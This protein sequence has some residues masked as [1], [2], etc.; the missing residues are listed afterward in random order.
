MSK[1]A[2][3]LA[4]FALLTPT[5]VQAQ[6]VEGFYSGRQA[7]FFIASAG[8]GG[9]DFYSRL[10]A[11]HLSRHLSGHPTFIMQNMP[12]AGGIVLANHLYNVAPRD[13]S[14]IGMLARAAGTWPLLRPKDKAPRYDATKFNWIGSP[15]Q[16]VGL[17][18]V[19]QPSPIKTL[20]DLK[21]HELILSGT[22]RA[23]PPSYYPRLFNKLFGTRFKVVE[24]YKGSQAALL[25]LERGEVQG[26]SSGSAAAP[27]RA[28]IAPWIKQGKIKILAQIGL[29]RDPEYPD[30]PLITDLA[31]SEADR[32]AVELVLTQ[33]RMAWP[34]VAPPG[35]PPERVKALRD[36]FD[37]TMNDPAFLT[38][39]AKQKLI[40]NPVSGKEIEALLS[41]AYATPKDVLARVTAQQ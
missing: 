40:I 32:Q 20:A 28:R 10:V 18:L 27:L 26:H 14:E 4:L 17:L 24:G 34:I 1:V 23:A 33:Q 12:G 13:G 19:R 2:V 3:S 21:T 30:V 8:G 25:A 38:D 31:I 9:Y 16:E 29:A 11:L 6:S 15:Q 39:A 5:A 7:K 22:S 37:A 41:R 35:V 36:A